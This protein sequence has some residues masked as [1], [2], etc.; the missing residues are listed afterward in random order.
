[1]SN[2]RVARR[3]AEAIVELAEERKQVDRVAED[4]GL[5]RRIIAESRDFA[6]F[7]RSPIIS[8]EKKGSVLTTLFASRLGA[9]TM[10]FLRLLTDKNR[11]GV[12]GQITEEFVRLRDERLGI[13]N[14]DV[15][16]V[17]ELTKEQ[18][19]ALERRFE[20]I[21]RKKVLITVSLDKQLQGG[22]VAKVGDTVFDG[23]VRHQ[24]ELL[25]ERFV[26]K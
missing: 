26:E 15:R 19:G 11:E 12:L 17:L 2:T 16:A 13:V 18:R 23:S 22:F 24:L 6:S 1:M 10:D 21:T 8:K 3:Y 14:V 4:F 5:L 9:L 20:E 25:R 7:L